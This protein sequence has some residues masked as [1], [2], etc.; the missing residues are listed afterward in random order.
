[1]RDAERLFLVECKD[2]RRAL[3][4]TARISDPDITVLTDHLRACSPSEPL[5]DA[6][7]LGEIMRRLY[8]KSV[9]HGMNTKVAPDQASVAA[10]RGSE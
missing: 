2:C 10:T 5:G 7:M 9:D 6:P 1:M 8:V 4:T 3:V